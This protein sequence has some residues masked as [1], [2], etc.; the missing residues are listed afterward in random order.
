[1]VGRTL[2]QAG[3][4]DTVTLEA[5][6]RKEPGRVYHLSRQGVRQEAAVC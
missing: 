5:A 2:R 4:E 3:F 1:M 6:P